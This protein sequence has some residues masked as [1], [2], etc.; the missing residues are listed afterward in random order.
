MSRRISGA[1]DSTY[2]MSDS[3]ASRTFN[4]QSFEQEKH[5]LEKLCDAVVS[6]R[7]DSGGDVAGAL[8]NLRIHVLLKGIP[9]EHEI[10]PVSAVCSEVPGEGVDNPN[11][12]PMRKTEMTLRGRVWLLMLGLDEI[13]GEIYLDLCKRKQCKL[14]N[15][16]RSDSFRTFPD[17]MFQQVVPEQRII[18]VLNAFVHEYGDVFA[19]V[20]GMNI[21]LA[22]FLYTMPEVNAFFAF[23]KFITQCFPIYWINYVCGAKAGC[24]LV[25]ECLEV[26]DNKLYNH[27]TSMGL[28]CEIYGFH[29]V[30]SLTASVPPFSELLKL[31]DILMAFGPHQN[32]IIVVAQ[33]MLKREQ[34]FS[35]KTANDC[36]MILNARHAT[37]L[38]A[39][40]TIR[41]LMHIS[42]RIRNRPELY[43]KLLRHSY[44][45]EITA[46]LIGSK[47][48]NF[49]PVG[50]PCERERERK[51]RSAR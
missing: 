16:I 14:Y 31:W 12:L 18:R 2:Y 42:S 45:P 19:Y 50:D 11:Y 10:F 22:P 6:A 48:V 26:S 43:R 51:S 38:K 5:E 40:N 33:V 21:I 13:D 41:M 32:V 27:I 30:Q 29:M 36:N 23:C 28:H 44:S 24:K 47:S 17:T 46:E 25:D 39:R 37:H 8:Q 7:R 1:S 34:L 49:T 20:Q 9:D 35:C 4:E 15:K 3:S